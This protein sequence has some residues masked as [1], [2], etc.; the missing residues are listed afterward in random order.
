M[1]GLALAAI[2][3]Q[4]YGTVI[5]NLGSFLVEAQTKEGYWE[6]FWWD[7]RIYGTFICCKLLNLLGEDASILRAA[8]WL[9][10]EISSSGGWGNG[11]EY[12]RKM[13]MGRNW[14]IERQQPDGSW[15]SSVRVR[16]PEP[17]VYRP[18]MPSER[19]ETT[20]VTDINRLFTTSSVIE[21]L[22]AKTDIL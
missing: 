3:R 17:H 22:G 10:A 15:C 13:E 2:D 18:W 11:Y 21:A 14:L 20:V 4:R 5:K 19:S 6:T 7:D 8:D 9:S 12:S 1:A 16:E